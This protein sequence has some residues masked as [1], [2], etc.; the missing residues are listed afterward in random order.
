MYQFQELYY[1]WHSS[2]FL[3][4]YHILNKS[5]TFARILQ[6]DEADKSKPLRYLTNSTSSSSTTATGA[7]EAEEST[8][9][10]GFCRVA[11]FGEVGL[12]VN[13]VNNKYVERR[14]DGYSD[15]TA[16]NSKLIKDVLQVGDCYFNSGD[17]LSRNSEGFYFWSDR[18]GDTFRW[19]GENVATTEVAEVLAAM[20]RMFSDVTVY[21]VS[22]PHCDGKVGMAA[23][24]LTV[25][26]EGGAAAGAESSVD[27]PRFH[28][29]CVAHLPAYA[30][31]AFIRIR[32]A[33]QITSTF[34]HQKG[35]LVKAGYDLEKV[36]TDKVYFY[37]HRDGK[38]S[39]LTPALLL[40]I[41]QGA[42]KL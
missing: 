40:K 23:V 20:P 41:D 39:P 29:E 33:M 9:A 11:A 8:A 2:V 13:V 34:K 5:N 18:V 22:V 10:A 3:Y 21:G 36:G 7:G 28:Q 25:S 12:V 42:M 16:T 30:R 31:P 27:W 17:L 15:D 6:V 24:V 37:S 26:P 14:F 1:Q 19:K 38:I 35:D 4:A 32:P